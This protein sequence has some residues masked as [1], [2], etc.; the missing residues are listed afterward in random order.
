MTNDDKTSGG[1]IQIKTRED[2]CP[3]KKL[4]LATVR[5]PVLRVPH[6]AALALDAEDVPAG[7]L[8][9]VR[10]VGQ[11]KPLRPKATRFLGT[12]SGHICPS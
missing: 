10:G 5:L 11:P 8:Q 9:S 1:L 3:T 2:V 6:R 4:D 12:Y 7:G